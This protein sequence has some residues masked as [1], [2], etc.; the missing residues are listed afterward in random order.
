MEYLYMTPIYVMVQLGNAGLW[1]NSKVTSVLIE[2]PEISPG[3]TT[4]CETSKQ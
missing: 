3:V 4:H 2:H 1:L